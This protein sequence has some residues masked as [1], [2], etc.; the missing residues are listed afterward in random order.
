PEPVSPEQYVWNDL[1]PI[2]DEELA[3]LPDK[4]RTLIVLSYLE[5]KTRKEVARQLDLPQGT[6]ASRL[7]AARTM[8]GKRLSRRGIVVSQ[9]VLG[10]VLSSQAALAS[11]PMAVVSSTIKAATLVAAGR[12]VVGVISPTVAALTGGVLKAMFVTKIQSVLAVV[13]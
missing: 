5:G 11:V 10:A 3:R 12:A 13:L 4:Y 8:L 2:L 9:A 6:V 7:A 1:Q